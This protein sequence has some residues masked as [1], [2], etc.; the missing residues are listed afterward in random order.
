MSQLIPLIQTLGPRIT[1]PSIFLGPKV[2]QQVKENRVSEAAKTV[3]FSFFIVT[4]VVLFFKGDFLL[5]SIPAIAAT[6]YYYLLKDPSK[7]IYRYLDWVLT[8]PLMLIALLT[9]NSATL[10]T[11]VG[12]VLAD[13][14]MIACGYKG[15]IS[16]DKK[17]QNIWFWLGMIAFFPIIYVLWN[18]KEHRNAVL[19]TLIMWCLYPIVWYAKEQNLFDSTVETVSYATMDVIAKV[20]LVTLLKL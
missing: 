11:K 7:P 1:I 9:A 14:I 20:G 2:V 13:I 19:L 12:I 10:S 18:L 5:S 3:A 16:T 4:A 17:E 15:I 6:S 8:T